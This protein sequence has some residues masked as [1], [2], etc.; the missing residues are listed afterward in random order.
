MSSDL[1][2]LLGEWQRKQLEALWVRMHGRF[3]VNI[4]FGNGLQ[5]NQFLVYIKPLPMSPIAIAEVD[6]TESSNAVC[7]HITHQPWSPILCGTRSG[8]FCPRGSPETQQPVTVNICSQFAFSNLRF[9]SKGRRP[10][11]PLPCRSSLTQSSS[12]WDVRSSCFARRS[13]N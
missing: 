11:R 6:L 7:W 3:F 10:L 4:R 1:R 5:K 8:R 2:E 9:A 12:A 13:A